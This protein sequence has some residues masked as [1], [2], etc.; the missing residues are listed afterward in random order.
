MRDARVRKRFINGQLGFH[1]G[2]VRRG[3]HRVHAVCHKRLR[4]QRDLVHGG[5]GALY[6]FNAPILQIFFC[7]RN[8]RRCRILADIVQKADL[9]R[10]G[11]LRK[12]QVHDGRRIEVVGGAGQVAAR[13]IHR[14]HHA[15]RD[16][17]GD[18][19]KHDRSIRALCGR[20]HRHGDRGGDRDHEVCAV[21]LEIGDDLAHQR[22]IGVAVVVFDPEVHASL[23]ADGGK[24]RTDAVHDLIEGGVIHIV[25][26]A[27]DIFLFAGGGVLR[28]LL[29]A[30]GGQGRSEH[31]SGKQN[32]KELFH[33]SYQPFYGLYRNGLNV[34]EDLTF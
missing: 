12:D 28:G 27:D 20:L 3:K 1:D 15:G 14:L 4:C 24:A 34:F 17:V 9:R 16:R 5:A 33:E 31:Q 22:R 7:R 18:S 21:R 6:V 19:R 11:L 26:D 29:T 2:V 10:I 25:A 32:C 23:L 30:A 8:G 13:R